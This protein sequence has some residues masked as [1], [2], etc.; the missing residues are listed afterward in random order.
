MNYKCCYK[1]PD[2]YVIGTKS[3]HST[4]KKYIDFAKENR[5]E[6]DRIWREKK[7][8]YALNKISKVYGQTKKY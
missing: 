6:K 2:R 7:L 8:G 4:C 1:C 3:C 5:E